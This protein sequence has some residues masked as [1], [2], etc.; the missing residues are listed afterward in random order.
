MRPRRC[1]GVIL[2]AENRLFTV[3]EPRHGPIIEVD[4]GHFGA[5]G[6]QT[7]AVNAETM[8]LARDLDP[9][10]QQVP[11][12]L[13]GASVAEFELPGRGPQRQRQELMPETDSEGGQPAGNLTKGLDRALDGRRITRAIGDKEAV[14]PGFEKLLRVH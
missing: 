1:L 9:A 3:P 6:D 14:N 2:H 10:S 8:V 11:N 4:V 5:R 12:R 13:I 7:V